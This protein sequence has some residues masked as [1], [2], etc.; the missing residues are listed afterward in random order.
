MCTK[1]RAMNYVKAKASLF[2]LLLPF[3]TSTLLG[4]NHIGM[5]EQITNYYLMTNGC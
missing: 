2:S 5:S 3:F 1:E 4:K